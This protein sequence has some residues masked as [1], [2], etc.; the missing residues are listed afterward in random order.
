MSYPINPI[1][2][3]ERDLEPV[4]RVQRGRD[5]DAPAERREQERRQPREGAPEEPDAAVP[6]PPGGDDDGPH[7][8]VR[9]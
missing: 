7:V 9:V 6:D 3:R 4:L 1:G 2:P 8:D 5:E